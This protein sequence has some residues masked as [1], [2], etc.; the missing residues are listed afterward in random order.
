MDSDTNQREVP[1]YL[2]ARAEAN[3]DKT[4]IIS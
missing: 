2:E 1:K 4:N 3:E